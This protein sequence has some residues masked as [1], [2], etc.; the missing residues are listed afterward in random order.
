MGRGDIAAYLGLVIETVS[1]AMRR[2]HEERVLSVRA[3][4]LRILDLDRLRALAHESEAPAST[5]RGACG[6]VAKA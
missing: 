4:R 5:C 6:S 1:R 2:L 3:H